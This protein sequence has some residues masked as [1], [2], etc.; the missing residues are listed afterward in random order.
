VVLLKLNEESYVKNGLE[1]QNIQ[2]KWYA[3]MVECHLVIQIVS[4]SPSLF[5]DGFHPMNI[6]NM[7]N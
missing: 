5:L 1:C 3:T 7:N 4:P 2:V 6:H